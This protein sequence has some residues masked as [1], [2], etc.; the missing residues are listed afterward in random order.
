MKP[1]F[2]GRKS[3]ATVTNHRPSKHAA[4]P[5]QKPAPRLRKKQTAGDQVEQFTGTRKQV[6][7]IKEELQKPGVRITP[8][9]LRWAKGDKKNSRV[10]AEAVFAKAK[11]MPGVVP[12]G[13]ATIAMDE[14]IDSAMAWAAQS[15]YE[16]AFQQ[17]VTFMG[18]P[19][20]SELAQ[21]AEYRRISE[22][23]ATEMT[24]KWI[25]I[26]CRQEAQIINGGEP[27]EEAE[28]DDD[29]ENVGGETGPEQNTEDDVAQDFAPP[30]S[31]DEAE[32][33][34]A[35][36]VGGEEDQQ[37]EIDDKPADELEDGEVKKPQIDGKDERVHQLEEEF[38]RLNVQDC[39]RKL[40]EQD[41]FFGRSH[42]FIDI[43]DPKTN[44]LA[45]SAMG[46]KAELKFPIG[47]G[48]D[49]VTEAKVKKGMLQRL[50]VVEPIWCYP[51]NYDSAN[52]LAV[53]WYAPSM[54]FVQSMEVHASRLLTFV[55]R[56][57]PDLLKPAYSFGGL[58]LSQ[59]A[60]P[61]VQNWLRT[62]QS[63]SDVVHSFS[64]FVLKTDM[65]GNNGGLNED[66]DEVFKRVDFFNDTRD[67]RGT[68]VVDKETEDFMNVAAPVSGLDKLQAQSQEHIC[69]VSGIPL[70]KY[71]GI[72]PSGLN[73][74]SE[75]E[76]QCFY[77]W[78]K[79][80]QI[81]FFQPNLTRIFHLAQI[82][83]WGKVDPDLY[84][85]WAPLREMTEKEKADARKSDTDADKALIDAGVISPEEVR[86]R[87]AKDPDSPYKG[88]NV[89]DVPEP[90]EPDLPPGMEGLMGDKGDE[91]GGAGPSPPPF[92]E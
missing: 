83:I 33:E 62:R 53:N 82:N 24:R 38:K 69:S 17:G 8:A 40:A 90:P 35:P 29:P 80:Y 6:R 79:A 54:W 32:V 51:A 86:G 18:Y 59:M 78:I 56:E 12:E 43:A 88:I 72:S 36:P 57:V 15:I 45:D 55:G 58:S 11:P 27:G 20:L 16:G 7:E 42:L 41:G 52:P 65:A 21:R 4:K 77:E 3:V 92:G 37:Q 63:V 44:V 34:E 5:K 85:E 1:V 81:A 87:L 84:F 67:N 71:T 2:P 60:Q 91:P 39:F 48:Q 31:D 75:F 64:V 49:M 47:D 19:Y 66:G 50:K 61:T 23:I 14:A 9:M 89:E 25:E 10:L 28:N 68:F 30:P 74:T 26:K 76:L 70:V 13:A 73:A 46:D 22:V